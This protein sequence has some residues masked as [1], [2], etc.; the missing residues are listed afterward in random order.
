MWWGHGEKVCTR[1]ELHHIVFVLIRFHSSLHNIYYK[2][3][4]E[5]KKKPSQVV[6][7]LLIVRQN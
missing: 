3:Q 4:Y 7:I 5:Q 6:S 1:G 2:K